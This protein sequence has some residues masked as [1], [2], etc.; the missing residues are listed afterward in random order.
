MFWYPPGFP[1]RFRQ[2]IEDGCPGTNGGRIF[3]RM[4]TMAGGWSLSIGIRGKFDAG[5]EDSA[6]GLRQAEHS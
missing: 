4:A 1:G 2:R 6:D 3:A 5:E